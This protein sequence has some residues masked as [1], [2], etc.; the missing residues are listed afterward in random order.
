M[1]SC[2]RP[3]SSSTCPATTTATSSLCRTRRPSPTGPPSCRPTS[4]PGCRPSSSSGDEADDA[5]GLVD[6]LHDLA[7]LEVL[8]D[9]GDGEGGGAR[10]VLGRVARELDGAAHLAV[11]LNAQRDGRVDR[12]RLVPG[13]PGRLHEEALATQALPGLV[14]QVR[15]VGAD[16]L[17]ERLEI[18]ER[19]R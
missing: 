6:E 19:R 14:A 7:A 18:L 11:D 12:E 2:A 10:D 1:A 16:Q 17:D 4:R 3:A 5:G 13:G 8:G 9:V 15:R